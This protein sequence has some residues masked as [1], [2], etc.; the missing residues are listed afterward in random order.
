MDGGVDQIDSRVAIQCHQFA[1]GGVD[2]GDPQYPLGPLVL[3][4]AMFDHL[5]S[6]DFRERFGRQRDAADPLQLLGFRTRLHHRGEEQLGDLLDA[7]VRV[8]F[9]RRRFE[10]PLEQ[11]VEAEFADEL[12]GHRRSGRR[13]DQDIGFA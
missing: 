5:A 6:H 8:Q 7:D 9:G 2:C 13:A 4:Q 11:R 12:R 10:L 1:C 3:G